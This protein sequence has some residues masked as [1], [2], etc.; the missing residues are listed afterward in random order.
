M[1]TLQEE[2]NLCIYF[3]TFI[4]L[5]S[6]VISF[7]QQCLGKVFTQ[8]VGKPTRFLSVKLVFS[9]D[10]TSARRV[11]FHTVPHVPGDIRQKSHKFWKKIFETYLINWE[12]WLR[13]AIVDSTIGVKEVLTAKKLRDRC[14]F[15]KGPQR[16]FFQKRLQR[17]WQTCLCLSSP[18]SST[19]PP[20]MPSPMSSLLLKPLLQPPWSSTTP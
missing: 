10:A 2:T 1:P 5:W 15:Q 11:C 4:L 16:N 19:C 3:L 12:V 18:I 9:T 13:F 17:N 8:S 14:G 7:S 20:G 6:K